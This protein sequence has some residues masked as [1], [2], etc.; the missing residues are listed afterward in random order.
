MAGG[1]LGG[2]VKTVASSKVAMAA[3]AAAVIY[4]AIQ[5]ADYATGARKAREALQ[6]M[7]E[8]AEK[9]KTTTADTFYSKGGL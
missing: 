5:L 7:K 1:G 2:F 6:G 9:W 8:T 4:G 3:L